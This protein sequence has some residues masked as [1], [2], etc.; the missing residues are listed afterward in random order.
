MG[1]H[2]WEVVS[3]IHKAYPA[4]VEQAEQNKR[5]WHALHMAAASKDSH[6]KLLSELLQLYPNAASLCDKDNRYPLHLACTSGKVWNDGL[7]SLFEANASAIRCRDKTDLLPLHIVAFRNCLKPPTESIPT[8]FN[9]SNRRS[10]SLM[11]VE[12]DKQTKKEKK[13]AQELTNIFEILISD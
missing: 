3:V 5:G 10:K 9:R 13:E 8:T 1:G 2:S 4:A 7:S 6:G 12:L 11:Q